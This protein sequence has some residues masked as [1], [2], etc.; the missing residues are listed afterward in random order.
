MEKLDRKLESIRNRNLNGDHLKSSTASLH[1][2]RDYAMFTPAT[3]KRYMVS[4]PAPDEH[5]L[6]FGDKRSRIKEE[7]AKSIGRLSRVSRKLYE[8]RR[9]EMKHL[10]KGRDEY[11]ARASK[12]IE[13]RIERKPFLGSNNVHRRISQNR[14]NGERDKY[15]R[16]LKNQQLLEEQLRGFGSYGLNSR[17]RQRL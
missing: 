16:I 14:F 10:K 12:P 15:N 3:P 7:I 9:E 11:F 2:G 1:R 17:S 6:M 13:R 5:R 8:E 4:E